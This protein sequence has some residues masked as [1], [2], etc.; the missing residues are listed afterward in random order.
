VEA[1]EEA[2]P[3]SFWADLVAKF[4]DDARGLSLEEGGGAGRL[5]E[6][7]GG[8]VRLVMDVVIRCCHGLDFPTETLDLALACHPCT[9][10]SSLQAR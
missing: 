3:T 6:G 8:G 4:M 9:S 2:L 1:T 5:D 7:V 10:L